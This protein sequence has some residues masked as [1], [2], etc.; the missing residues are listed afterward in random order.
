MLLL[1][2]CQ[3]NENK[4]IWVTELATNPTIKN[5][6]SRGGNLQREMS[7]YSISFAASGYPQDMLHHS[8]PGTA[9]TSTNHS[10]QTSG[11][12]MLGNI[13]APVGQ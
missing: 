4:P 10:P 2:I 8:S 6:P 3:F 7:Y 11:M 12:E 13:T 5:S 9:W 1:Q